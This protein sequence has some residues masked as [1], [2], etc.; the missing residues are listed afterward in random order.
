MKKVFSY[1][2]ILM[3]IIIFGGC[4][5]LNRTPLTVTFT[6]ISGA[7]STDHTIKITVG[8][9][10]DYENY[11]LDIL[12]K[13]DKLVNLT[14]FQEFSKDEQKQTISVG[15]E[16]V[17][18]DEYKIF[19]MEEEQTDSMVGY[20]DVLAT[21]LVINSSADAT[22]TFLAVVGENNN[23]SFNQIAKASK[24]YVLTVKAHTQN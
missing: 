19:N 16:F 20:A 1:I 15:S 18:L 11:Y 7:L 14:I 9:E 21:T 5:A 23:G 6:D 24:E 13:A 17:S 2:A 12:V 10:K 22:L 3:C 4:N 8:E